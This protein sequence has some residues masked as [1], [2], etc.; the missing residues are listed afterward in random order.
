MAP[1]LAS[2]VAPWPQLL[3]VVPLH[4]PGS[5]ELREYPPLFL[6]FSGVVRGLRLVFWFWNWSLGLPNPLTLC[7]QSYH[8]SLLNHMTNYF[9]LGSGFHLNDNMWEACHRSTGEF[10][11]SDES[12]CLP[13]W[14][15]KICFSPLTAKPSGFPCFYR[16]H[17]V[18]PTEKVLE[19][20][21]AES[22]AMASKSISGWR[23][24]F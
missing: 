3:W 24:T 11:V 12:Y 6:E 16:S 22:I 7:K 14:L 1:A 4:S 2:T 23:R 9:Y 13:G 19:W 15:H 10:Q 20:E 8:W 5:Q 18:L 21:L 17:S